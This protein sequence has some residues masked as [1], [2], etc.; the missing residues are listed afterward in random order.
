M[1][2]DLL[3]FPLFLRSVPDHLGRMK[4]HPVRASTVQKFLES[5]VGEDMHAKRIL[6]LSNAVLGTVHAAAL[7]IHFIGQALAQARGLQAKHAVKQVDRLLRYRAAEQALFSGC[8]R[9]RRQLG[10]EGL[11]VL[12]DAEH[13]SEEL[14]H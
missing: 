13:R 12:R 11:A 2:A 8:R 5:I 4:Q 14:S 7:A 10:D 6:S 3:H 1:L 9:L